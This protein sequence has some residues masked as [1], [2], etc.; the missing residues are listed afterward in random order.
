MPKNNMEIYDASAPALGYLYQIRYAL[1]ISLK[2]MQEVDDTDDCFISIESVDD[3]SF[4]NGDDPLEVIQTKHHTNKGNLSDRS[5]DI[6][7]TVRI[8]SELILNNPDQEFFFSLITT[9]SFPSGSLLSKLGVEP[10]SR[11][12]DEALSTMIEISGEITNVTNSKAYNAF[13]SLDIYQQKKLINS[14]YSVGNS[15]NILEVEE[16]IK[17]KIR[18]SATL[19]HIDAFT[20]RLEGLWFKRV[21]NLFISDDLAIPMAELVSYIDE[22]RQ[23]FLPTNLPDDFGDKEP[24]EAYYADHESYVFVEQLRLIDAPD[25]VLKIAILNFY[26]AFEQRSRWSREGLVK[27]GE[28][29]KYLNILKDEWSHINSF[30]EWKNESPRDLYEQCQ[31]NGAKPIRPEFKSTFVA[32]GSYHDLANEKKIGWHPDY[33]SLLS[34]N[35]D[36]EVG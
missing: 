26:R 31:N 29:A 30:V 36:L 16:L 8:W 2:K 21:I 19:S 20:S 25:S 33:L 14:I 9:Q 6:W 3:I 5:T 12:V 27:P 1:F 18:L 17:K 24:E 7:K 23:Q 13:N 34:T 10:K 4:E 11:N 15:P 35:D 28:I 22:L 32:R